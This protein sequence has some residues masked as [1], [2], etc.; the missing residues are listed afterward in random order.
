MGKKTCGR[1]L[2]AGEGGEA[3]VGMYCLREEYIF[4]K[5]ITF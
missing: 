1:G 5:K 4:F 3:A 2:G